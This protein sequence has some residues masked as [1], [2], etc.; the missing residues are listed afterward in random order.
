MHV[1]HLAELVWSSSL[2]VRHAVR[3]ALT[4]IETKNWE[5]VAYTVNYMVG[6]KQQV[7]K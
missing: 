1:L 6:R 7:V 4:L 2:A 3:S 5:V